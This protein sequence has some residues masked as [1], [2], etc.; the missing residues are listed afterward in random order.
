MNKCR[1]CEHCAITEKGEKVC[2]KY[3]VYLGYGPYTYCDGPEFRLSLK[4]VIVA[5]V[6][7]AVLLSIMF[8]QL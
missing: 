3:L 7:A 8:S 5:G 6:I 2:A 4:H 1:L